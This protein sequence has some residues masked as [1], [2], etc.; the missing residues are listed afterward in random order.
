MIMRFV[1]I[2]ILFALAFVRL[3]GAD[4]GATRTVIYDTQRNYSVM[5]L[6]SVSDSASGVSGEVT[7]IPIGAGSQKSV[8]LRITRSQFEKI[9]SS[10]LS[11][12]IAQYPIEKARHAV[13]LD[14]YYVFMSGGHKYAVPKKKASPVAAALARQMEAYANDKAVGLQNLPKRVPSTE[15]ERVIVH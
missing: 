14:Y 9:W 1:L 4:K 7:V 6:V 12:G 3:S 2:T 8:P 11:S 5:V 15:P 13:D 10:F